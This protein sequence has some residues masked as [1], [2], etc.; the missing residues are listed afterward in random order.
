MR[1]IIK[2]KAEFDIVV[3]PT[4]YAQYQKLKE[5]QTNATPA[6][7]ESYLRAG[8]EKA[9]AAIYQCVNDFERDVLTEASNCKIEAQ[10]IMESDEPR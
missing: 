3:R 8:K 7:C 4:N 2:I 6:V 10:L 9:R 1:N 5:F